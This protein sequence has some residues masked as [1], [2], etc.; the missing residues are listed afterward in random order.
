MIIERTKNATRNIIFGLIQRVFQIVFPFVIRTV[1]IY[2]MGIE[3][4]GLNSLFV[5]VL[6]VLNLVELGVGSAMVFSMYKP[7]AEDDTE[8]ICALL[9]LYKTYYRA[10]GLVICV[11]G[12]L[13]TPFVPYLIKCDLPSELNVYVLY[14]LSLATTVLS[15]WLFAY[16]NSLFQAHQRLDIVSRI[17]VVV[18]GVFYLIQIII[19]VCT[20]DYYL[21]TISTLLMQAAV[22]IVTAIYATK[23][24]PDYRAYGKLDKIEVKNINQ[25]IRDLFTAKIGGTIT[26]SVDTVVVSAFLGLTTLAIFQNYSFILSAVFTVVAIIFNSV[27]A[28][29]GNSFVT[30]TMDKNYTDFKRFSFIMCWIICFCCS[31]FIALLQPFVE[32]WVGEELLLPIEMVFL[33]CIYFYVYE[34]AMIWATVKDAAGIWHEDRFRPLIGATANLIMN[35]I[36]VQKIGLYGILLSTILSY[37]CISM[38]WLVRNLFTILFKRSAWDYLKMLL[39]NMLLTFFSCVIVFVICESVPVAGFIGLIVRFV[40]CLFFSNIIQFLF[41]RQEPEFEYC[42][43][44]IKRILKLR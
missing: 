39:T 30:E 17:T 40:I 19:I 13:F 6:Q 1:M 14:W 5:S 26:N 32:L 29:M 22:N 41:L 37:V 12:L 44:L 25:R 16:K 4:V 10:I 31:C 35:I 27:I 43:S 36:F 15:Y 9:K 24:F 18:N 11:I 23:L 20:K 3:Y 38:P 2:F 42:I 21:Y 28:G 34:I 8:R 33:F 7:I